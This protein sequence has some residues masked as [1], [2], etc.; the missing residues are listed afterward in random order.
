MGRVIVHRW[1]P[2]FDSAA[3]MGVCGLAGLGS[4]GT[5]SLFIGLVP[6]GTHFGLYLVGSLGISGLAVLAA[7]RND[8]RLK[9]VANAEYVFLLACG[10]AT[11]FAVIGALA[12]STMMDWDSLAYH[13]AV[14]KTWIIDGQIHSIPYIHHSNF[15][16]AVDNL[17]L[18][19]LQWGGESGAK[20]FSAAFLV[21]GLLTAFGLSRQEYGR[22]A[23]WWAALG[24]ASVPLIVWESGTAYIDVAHGLY[25]G[26]GIYFAAKLLARPT[27]RRWLWLA[28][29]FL[30]F[31]AGSKYTGLQT[32][33]AASL[34]VGLGLVVKKQAAL[35]FKTAILLGFVAMAL[36]SPWYIRN[37][38]WKGNPVFPFFYS[39]LGGN[40]WDQRRA[41]IY[42]HQQNTFGVGREPAADPMQTA[43]N[44]IRLGRIGHSILGLAYQPGR[45]VD[46]GQE[47]GEGTPLGAFGAVL[48]AGMMAWLIA[49][50]ARAFE[51]GVLGISLVTLAMWFALSQQSRYAIDLAL[52]LA[53]LLGGGVI[54]LRAGA[55]LATL[56]A[57]QTAYCLWLIWTAVAA[58]QLLVATG[59][60]SAA[61]YQRRMIPFYPAAQQINKLGPHSKTAL[62][63][64]VFGFLLDVPY[65][66]ANPGHSTLIPYDDLNDGRQYSAEMKRLGFTHVFVSLS[67]IVTGSEEASEWLSAAGLS[68]DPQPY[69][70]QRRQAL[71]SDWQ[72]RFKVLTAEASRFG[73][74]R[75]VASDHHWVLFEVR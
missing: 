68:D 70:A 8:W 75:V 40:G 65:V 64:E 71:M 48:I 38:V 29:L 73:G 25:A 54:R 37:V 13:L 50:R 19:G 6:G 27:E 55:L 7:N 23:G 72:T 60:V 53:V 3:S 31:A 16:Q 18:W 51:F 42:S 28:A 24:I 35:G 66:W 67:P 58:D 30:S 4:I 39:K 41:D 57:G 14:P 63:D 15:P 2:D 74:I 12:P 11:L 33:F 47:R 45:F 44:P 59:Q 61:N 5:I 62:Y 34:V 36:A 17:Y 21:Y 22:R 9:G 46:R 20:A 43:N 10:L 69:A 56:A 32:I 52:P 26:V 49:G 1:L